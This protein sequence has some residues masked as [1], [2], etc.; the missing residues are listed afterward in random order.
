M[1]LLGVGCLTLGST[2]ALAAARSDD[3]VS[4]KPDGPVVSIHASFPVNAAGQT[5]GRSGGAL[6]PTQEP[7][8]ILA[9]A[10]NG[11]VGY[12]EKEALD[13][14]TGANVASPEEAI[15]WQEQQA[16]RGPVE[17]PVYESD[18]R[19][20]VGAFQIQPSVGVVSNPG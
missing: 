2:A 3:G 16:A 10:T 6:D 15:V 17:I 14:A 11:K 19:T 7:D 18:G 4:L 9:E 8:L 1:I 12:V 5:Y 13:E 20:V